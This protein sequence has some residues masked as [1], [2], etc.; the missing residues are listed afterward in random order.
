MHRVAGRRSYR[1][2]VACQVPRREAAGA[3]GAQDLQPFLATDLHREFQKA[4]SP[5]PRCRAFEGVNPSYIIDAAGL[6]AGLAAAGFGAGFG[7]VPVT[8]TVVRRFGARQSI[9]CLRF[10]FASQNLVTFTG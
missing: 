7:R 1:A 3:V 9:S 10:I 6:A 4:K 2:A 5:A 8:S